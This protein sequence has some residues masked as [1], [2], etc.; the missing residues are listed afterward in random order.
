MF[1]LICATLKFT[2]ASYLS[3]AVRLSAFG[4]KKL[5]KAL[6]KTFLFFVSF[7]KI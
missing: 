4:G 7:N 1:V 5:D 3:S 6:F 2:A